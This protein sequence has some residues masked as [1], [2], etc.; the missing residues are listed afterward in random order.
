MSDDERTQS[1]SRRRRQQAREAGRVAH[2]PELTSAAGLLAAAMLLGLWADDLA[3]G[4]VELVR[5]PFLAT[6]PGLVEPPGVSPELVAG[7]IRQA[8]SRVLTPLLGMV[9]GVVAVMAAVHLLQSGFLWAPGLVAADPTRLLG[10][11]AATADPAAA[12]GRGT[13]AI[14]KS[15]VLVAVSGWVLLADLPALARLAASEPA[16]LAGAAGSITRSLV[17][18]LGMALAA[19]GGLDYALRW[20]RFE[21]SLRQTPEEG[22]QDLRETEG[23]PAARQQRRSLARAWRHDPADLLPGAVLLVHGPPG[24]VVLLGGGPPPGRPITVRRIV[25]GK[26]A[27]ALRRVAASAGLP[28]AEAPDLA[29]TFARGPAAASSLTPV[30]ADRLA[31]LWPTS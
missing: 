16:A 24:L 4:L 17:L 29:A 5:A 18:T 7:S 10:G 19:L 22:R 14:V 15:T 13:W 6:T 23:D 21:A 1:P 8:I 27:F 28:I 26:D 31:T 11:F 20:R 25:R 12:V 3:R 2:S 30:L 9:G